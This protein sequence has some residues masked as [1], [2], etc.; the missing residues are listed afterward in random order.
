ML[1]MAHDSTRWQVATYRALS[2]LRN[3]HVSVIAVALFTFFREWEK[4]ERW[5]NN[6]R[7]Q[8]QAGVDDGNDDSYQCKSGPN[9]DVVQTNVNKSASKAAA[10][11][12]WHRHRTMLFYHFLF[13]NS[14]RWRGKKVLEKKTNEMTANDLERRE[15]WNSVKEWQHQDWKNDGVGETESDTNVSLILNYYSMVEIM[16][17][18]APMDTICNSR[19]SVVHT[20]RR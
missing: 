2:Q 6:N 16:S 14:K 10:T 1:M 3:L 18:A 8:R 17:M 15:K 7:I 19:R 13:K 5:K 11:P 9:Q 4:K 12:T 20:Y